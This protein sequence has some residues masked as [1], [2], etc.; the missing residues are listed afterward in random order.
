[1]T[2]DILEIAEKDNLDIIP[3]SNLVLGFPVTNSD[4]ISMFI[5]SMELDYKPA[6]A[7]ETKGLVVEV[8]NIQDYFILLLWWGNKINRFDK[9]GT[10]I[11][12]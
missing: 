1:M 4:E 7:W 12:S 10:E 3:K 2:S 11:C 6:M 8:K 5:S 9:D